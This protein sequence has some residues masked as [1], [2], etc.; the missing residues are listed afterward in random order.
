MANKLYNDTSVKAIADAIRAKNGTTN[1]YTIGEMAGAINDIPTGEVNAK[2]FTFSSA[3]PVANQ[4]VKIVSADPDVAAHYT[5]PNAMITVRKMTNNSTMG[6]VFLMNSNHAFG[7]AHGV[8]M[9]FSGSAN[10]AAPITTNLATETDS[11]SIFCNSSGDIFVH[12]N[13]TNN[14]FGGADY[15]ITFTW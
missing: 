6:L 8:Y 12:C 7:T 13:R 11:I 14:N 9:N 10:A 1:T 3:E 4:S 2:F 15:I 5:D